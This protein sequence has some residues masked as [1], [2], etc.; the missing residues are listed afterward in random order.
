RRAP[1]G[2]PADSRGRR[3]EAGGVRSGTSP[4][5]LPDSRARSIGRMTPLTRIVQLGAAFLC[6]NLARAA[7]GFGLTLAIGRG[8]GVDRFGMWI[9]C[10]TWASTLTTIADLGFGVLLAR[11]GARA[12]TDP[13]RLVA[14]ALALRLAVAVPLGVVLTIAAGALASS[15]EAVAALR[16]AALLGVSGAAYGCFGA[17]FRSQPRWLPARLGS[18]TA[19]RAVPLPASW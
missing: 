14:G 15:G 6:S 5:G 12:G 10:T 7:I 4:C 2:L 3:S 9:L 11:D 18:E 17:L 1:R 19:W 13:I 8:L 16:V